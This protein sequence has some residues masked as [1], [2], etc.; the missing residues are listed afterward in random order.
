MTRL[1][2]QVL[3]ASRPSGEASADNFRLVETPVPPLADGQV[4]VR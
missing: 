2:Q 3:L 4:L 1:N